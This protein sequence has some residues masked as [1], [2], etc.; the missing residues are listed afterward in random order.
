M[1]A[2]EMDRDAEG[3]LTDLGREQL[4]E[5]HQSVGLLPTDNTEEN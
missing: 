1:R 4:V 3:H 5:W 2:E